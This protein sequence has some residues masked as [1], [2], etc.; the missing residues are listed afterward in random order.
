MQDR[1]GITLCHTKHQSLIFA[2]KHLEDG[3]RTLSD[4]SI[5]K[6]SALHLVLHKRGSMQIF[7]KP[8]TSK[9]ITLEVE[10]SSTIKNVMAKIQDNFD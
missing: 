9:T 3:C 8:L 7:L 4:F 1:E 2:G 5:E 10:L 6:E